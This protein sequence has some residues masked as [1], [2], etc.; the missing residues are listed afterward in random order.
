MR[1]TSQQRRRL[2]GTVRTRTT[3]PAL[4]K[5]AAFAAAAL[6]LAACG[7]GGGG[8][9]ATTPGAGGEALTLGF[10]QVGAESG[11]RTAHTK[12]GPGGAAAAR[13]G[14]QFSHAPQKQGKQIKASCPVIP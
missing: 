1:C 2:G 12:A 8:G 5:L 7:G 9:G 10:S 11:W 6:V 3:L 4:G 14:L 13:V